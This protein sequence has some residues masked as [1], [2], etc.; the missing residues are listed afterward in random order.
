MSASTHFDYT[1]LAVKQRQ[2]MDINDVPGIQN[3]MAAQRKRFF[4]PWKKP[5]YVL[6]QS[7]TFNSWQATGLALSSF[8]KANFVDCTGAL[9]RLPIKVKQQVKNAFKAILYIFEGAVARL[10]KI[11]PSSMPGVACTWIYDA[12]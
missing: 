5:W 3:G 2:L 6:T 1:I 4:E 8:R 7:T 9:G 10:F 11:T 12:M